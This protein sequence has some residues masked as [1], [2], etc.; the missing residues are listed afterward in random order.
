LNNEI[1]EDRWVEHEACMGERRNAHRVLVK[2][3]L[4]KIA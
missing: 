4:E 1:K 3:S 2:K